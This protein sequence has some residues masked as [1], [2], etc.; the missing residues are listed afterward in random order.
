MPAPPKTPAERL[1]AS[2]P[3]TYSNLLRIAAAYLEDPAHGDLDPHLV[4]TLVTGSEL[5]A[6]QAEQLVVE[7]DAMRR[8]HWA[9]LGKRPPATPREPLR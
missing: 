8:R 9:A 2:L 4:F 3:W 6:Q 5:G 7:L 1:A